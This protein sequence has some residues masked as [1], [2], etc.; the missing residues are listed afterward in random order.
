MT[1]LDMT[2]Q[3]AQLSSLKSQS[4]TVPTTAP[5][6]AKRRA[7]APVEST[8]IK[9][10]KTTSKFSDVRTIMLRYLYKHDH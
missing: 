7:K 5:T 3:E 2:D 10:T 1:A 9:K 4:T 8:V 6:S